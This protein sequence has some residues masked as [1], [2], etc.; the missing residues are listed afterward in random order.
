MEIRH[1]PNVT[2]L[3]IQDYLVVQNADN[4]ATQKLTIATLFEEFMALYTNNTPVRTTAQA[5]GAVTN[6]LSTT[7]SILVAANA[8]R[9]GLTIYNNLMTTVFIDTIA[10]VSSTAYMI[11]LPAGAYYEM[12]ASDCL[13]TGALSAI[14][15]TGTGSILVREFT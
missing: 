5:A 11:A 1:L 4:F 3:Q 15:P 7:A 8:N 9:K 2:S 6:S 13:Y 10:T 12:P 14:L